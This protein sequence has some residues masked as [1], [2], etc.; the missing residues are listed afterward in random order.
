MQDNESGMVLAHLPDGS[1]EAVV[2]ANME[3]AHGG[4]IDLCPGHLLKSVPVNLGIGFQGRIPMLLVSPES[5]VCS[6]RQTGE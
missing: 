3:D 6:R 5:N 4:S 1:M 2:V